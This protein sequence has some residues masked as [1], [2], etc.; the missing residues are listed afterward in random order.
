[1]MKKFPVGYIGR[2]DR[3]APGCRDPGPAARRARGISR[4]PVYINDANA[5]LATMKL[6]TASSPVVGFCIVP[7]KDKLRVL[8]VLALGIS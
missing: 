3:A 5:F 4:S 8:R 7:F 6:L 2:Y 1:M